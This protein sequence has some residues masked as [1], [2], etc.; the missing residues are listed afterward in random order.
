VTSA[1]PLH[2]MYHFLFFVALE[3]GTSR[4]AIHSLSFVLAI[5]MIVFLFQLLLMLRQYR[6]KMSLALYFLRELLLLESQQV[7]LPLFP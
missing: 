1:Y 7:V 3:F 2:T 6:W 4:V 5:P